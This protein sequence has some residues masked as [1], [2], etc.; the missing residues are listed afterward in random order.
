MGEL[1]KMRPLTGERLIHENL[2]CLY[3]SKENDY[4]LN[5]KMRDKIAEFIWV[6]KAND[7]MDGTNMV[8]TAEVLYSGCLK[9]SIQEVK[10]ITHMSEASIYRFRIKMADRLKAFL[11]AESIEDN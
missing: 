6:Y 7:K 5:E 10:S 2:L 3:F 1:K 9:S 11:T 4:Y 8:D